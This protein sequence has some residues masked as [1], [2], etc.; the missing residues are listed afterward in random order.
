LRLPP[1]G[2]SDK[3]DTVASGIE[4]PWGFAGYG[5]LPFVARPPDNLVAALV[6]YWTSHMNQ[7]LTLGKER[8]GQCCR[9]KYEELVA[10]PEGVTK[11]PFQF[12]EVAGDSGAM[13]RALINGHRTPPETFGDYKVG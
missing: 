4:C 11:R 6:E 2:R 13:R 1:A 5:Y 12:L 10:S 3:M 9:L 8:P 7:S